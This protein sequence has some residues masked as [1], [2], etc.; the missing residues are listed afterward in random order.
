MIA[1]AVGWMV[2]AD[3]KKRGMSV[4]W[5]W[6]VFLLMIVFLPIYFIARKPLLTENKKCQYCAEL[7]KNEAKVCKFC[8]KDI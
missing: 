5:G 8:G 1:A 2:G 3:A 4:A 7:V 6:G